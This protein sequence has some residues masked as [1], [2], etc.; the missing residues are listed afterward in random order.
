[1]KDNQTAITRR[2]GGF[3]GIGTT[4]W[5]A[6][7][8]YHVWEVTFGLASASGETRS[9]RTRLAIETAQSSK[10]MTMRFGPGYPLVRL[11]EED[12]LILP[13]RS[14]HDLAEECL[15]HRGTQRY[16][17]KLLRLP[18][19]LTEDGV[20]AIP[21]TALVNGLANKPQLDQ[22]IEARI[23][24]QRE[25]TRIDA[26]YA[27]GQ[28]F[29]IGT[30]SMQIIAGNMGGGTYPGLALFVAS[31]VHYYCEKYQ[32]PSDIIL[33]GTTPSALSGGDLVTAQGNFATFARQAV[34][35]I[36]QPR[37]IVFHAFTGEELRH[38]KAFISR[39][40][41][42]SPSTGKLSFGTREEI[43]AQMALTAG[44]ILDTGYGAFAEAQFRDHDK[45]MLDK[46]RYGFRG[47]CR[48]GV[49]RIS[50]DRQRN[51]TLARAAATKL[52]TETLLQGTTHQ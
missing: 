22:L 6:A 44:V 32:L 10:E 50:A 49:A 45:D 31:R 9:A 15:R 16:G 2:P 4:G 39:I 20:G 19:S 42:W 17:E 13:V 41:P 46:S 3:W 28:S 48:M 43:A 29:T 18:D 35:A 38:D 36:E 25:R 21:L 1:M 37:K 30:R 23:L 5:L 26:H 34:T 7:L 52:V 12:G 33:F 8:L 24:A 47:F 27:R 40:V 51:L 14:I 11:P